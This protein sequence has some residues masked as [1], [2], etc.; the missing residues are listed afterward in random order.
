MP[1]SRTISANGIETSLSSSRA[2]V[3]WCCSAMAG[4]N[5]PIPGGIRSRAHRGSRFPCRRPRY[6]RVSAG[7][8]RLPTSAPTASSTMSATWSRW[9]RRLAKS[10][11]SLSAMT[12]AR[13]SPGTRRCSGPISSP[14]SRASAFRRPSAA[15][16]GRSKPCAQSGIT[17]FYWQYFQTPG[18]AEAE[19]ERDVA[20]TMRIV[21]LGRGFSDPAAHQYVQEGKGF[22]ANAEPNRPLP[23]WLTEADPG[24]FRGRLPNIRLSRRAQLVSQHRPQLGIDRTMAGRANPPAVPVHRGI[25]GWRHHRADRRQAGQGDG[26]RAVELAAKAPFST[27]PVTQYSRSGPTRSTPP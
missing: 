2:R 11:P 26:T 24:L 20:V 14:R 25:E 1:S 10:R 6:A 3:R 27:A 9:W 4:R 16:A 22:L 7:P 5:Y 18:V 13:R 12:G 21:W 17:N 15:A 23:S 8:A 19:F